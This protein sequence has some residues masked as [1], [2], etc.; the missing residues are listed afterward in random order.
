[1]KIINKFQKSG[2]DKILPDAK[3]DEFLFEPCGYSINGLLPHGQYFT[4]HVTPEPNCSYVSFE[5]NVPK[6]DQAQMLLREL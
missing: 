6:V 2:I 3:I 4:I 1:M 5:S